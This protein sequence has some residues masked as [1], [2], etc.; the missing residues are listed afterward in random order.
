MVVS[1]TSWRVIQLTIR[2]RPM[3]IFILFIFTIFVYPND[4]IKHHNLH[5]C[6]I[7]YRTQWEEKWKKEKKNSFKMVTQLTIA[8]SNDLWVYV[9][10]CCCYWN[11]VI[12][13]FSFLQKNIKYFWAVYVSSKNHTPFVVTFRSILITIIRNEKWE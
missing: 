9:Y 6:R 3:C 1:L 4:F 2:L 13:L 8:Y 10:C 7:Q 5:F 11:F 12:F